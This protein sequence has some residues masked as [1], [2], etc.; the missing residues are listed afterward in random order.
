MR[1]HVMDSKDAVWIMLH[2]GH[3]VGVDLIQMFAFM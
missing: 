3:K 1:L 2:A